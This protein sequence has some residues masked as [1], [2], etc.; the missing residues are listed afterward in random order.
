MTEALLD[1]PSADTLDLI[2]S[3]PLVKKDAVKREFSIKSDATLFR[4]IKDGRLPKPV[5]ILSNNYWRW[6]DVIAARDA[7]VAQ[8]EVGE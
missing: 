1:Q 3:D 6:S 5:S 4:W 8:A 2:G 7:M